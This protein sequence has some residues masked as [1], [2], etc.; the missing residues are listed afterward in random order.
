MDVQRIGNYRKEI[1]GLAAVWI[2]LYHVWDPVYNEKM[3]LLFRE[4]EWL[5]Q[6]LGYCGVEI[7][8]FLSGM[9]LVFAIHKENTKTFYFRRW[10]RV[11]PSFFIWFTLSTLIRS[12]KMIFMEYLGRITF[13]SNWAEDLLVYKW[14]VAAILL[15][16]LCFPIYYY[17]FK[18]QKNC[19]FF[20]VCLIIAENILLIVFSSFIR[21]DLFLLLDRIP[22]FLV[23][24]LT[25]ELCL[26]RKNTLSFKFEKI[27]WILMFILM[28]GALESDFFLHLRDLSSGGERIKNMLNLIIAVCICVVEA[29]LLDVL[30]R[31]WWSK[32][33]RRFLAFIGSLSL[34]FYLTHESISLKVKSYNVQLVKWNIF[35]QILILI[36][37][38]CLSLAAAWVVKKTVDIVEQ[39]LTCIYRNVKIS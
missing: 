13:Y 1:M 5:I 11:Y 23:G 18:K 12:D 34:E 25:G 10:K 30:S 2:F 33:I 29:K 21:S 36:I 8:L 24:I 20:T 39:S 32:G 28:L 37:C 35:N 38:F 16:Y 26:E 31:Y 14:Y 6:G 22:I 17:I 27:H 15:L 3:L 4:I 7:F 9:G 19:V